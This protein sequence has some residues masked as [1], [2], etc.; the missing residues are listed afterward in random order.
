MAKRSREDAD[1][2]TTDT[3][4]AKKQRKG[5]VVGPG[6]LPEGQHKRKTQQIKR[7]LIDKAKL[8]K[9]YAKVKAQTE[10]ADSNR[11]RPAVVPTDH[12]NEDEEEEQPSNEPHPDR[13]NLID[14]EEIAP[15]RDDEPRRE[16][17]EDGQ[18]RFQRRER[19]PKSI[20]FAREHRQATRA[21]QEV[22]ERRRAREEAE[23]QR[24]QKLEE[25]DKFRRAMAKARTP[26]RDGK[27]KLG[28]EST[29]LLD[30]V[31][32]MVAGV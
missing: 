6:N 29:I 27:K 26:G 24:Q 1:A 8:K 17:G 21:K 20:P 11:P 18:R 15:T 28:R 9:E 23:R 4:I 10:A 2:P 12:Q 31:K 25:R 14:E 13:Q 30:K 19:K 5:F 7:N 22:E 16:V 3:K 32:K